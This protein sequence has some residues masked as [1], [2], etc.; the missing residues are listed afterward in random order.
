MDEQLKGPY[1]YWQHSHDFEAVPGGTM[2]RDRIRYALPFGPAGRFVHSVAVRRRLE[3]IFNYRAR[4]IDGTFGERGTD[5]VADG[6]PGIAGGR[7]SR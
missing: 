6:Q 4:V 5:V 3:E 1:S 2:V 7:L